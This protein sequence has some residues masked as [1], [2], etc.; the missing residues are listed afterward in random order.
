MT[1][2][3]RACRASSHA[4]III[5]EVSGGWRGALQTKGRAQRVLLRGQRIGRTPAR[6]S[7]RD[8]QGRG[9]AWRPN[10][11][12]CFRPAGSSWTHAGLPAA[13]VVRD[14]E[15]GGER[16]KG[17]LWASMGLINLHTCLKVSVWPH[18]IKIVLRNQ[19]KLALTCSR[20]TIQKFTATPRSRPRHPADTLAAQSHLSSTVA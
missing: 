6:L 9:R 13:S 12:Q 19:T 20:V 14:R 4:I 15:G 11:Y 1:P 10:N 8:A 18:G 3:L 17:L 16:G 5:S 7:L 2:Q